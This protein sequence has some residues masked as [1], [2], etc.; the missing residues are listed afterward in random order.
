MHY[1][2]HY[3]CFE[4]D[5]WEHYDCFEF[6]QI[7]LLLSRNHTVK[8]LTLIRSDGY[9]LPISVFS[10]LHLTTLYPYG[11][12]LDYPPTFD[13]FG[14]LESLY[15]NNVKISTKTLLHLLSNCHSLKSSSLVSTHLNIRSHV[16]DFLNLFEYYDVLQEI[17]ELDDECTINELL[18]CLPVIEHL[19]ISNRAFQVI[20]IHIIYN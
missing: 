7:I 4:F 1:W 8:K 14:S 2:E 11:F 18:K 5:Y 13:G 3:D 6:D 12:D 20:F 10:L 16:M 17:G 19:T 15:L 9:K